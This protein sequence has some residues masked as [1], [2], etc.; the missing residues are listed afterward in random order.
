MTNQPL[1]LSAWLTVPVIA[2]FVEVAKN[3]F[4]RTAAFGKCPV[5]R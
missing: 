3:S 5:F 1:S 2:S 4:I